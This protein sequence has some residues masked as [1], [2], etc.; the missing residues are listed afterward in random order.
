VVESQP[1][2]LLVAGSIPVS[3]SI[4]STTCKI[5]NF[6]LYSVY[7]VFVFEPFPDSWFRE[8][9]FTGVIGGGL[10]HFPD[11]GTSW[12]GFGFVWR[13]RVVLSVRTR[14]TSHVLKNALAESLVSESFGRQNK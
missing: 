14:K 1:S 11:P 3:R 8:T 12:L 13:A 10:P 5:L 7:S 9:R 6:T 2:K 4:V